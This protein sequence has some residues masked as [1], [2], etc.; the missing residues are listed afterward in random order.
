MCTLYLLQQRIDDKLVWIY[1]ITGHYIVKSGYK[2]EM[3]DLGR[4]FP[5]V[6]HQNLKLKYGHYTGFTKA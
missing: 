5:D 4:V 1:T 3:I 6:D 2:M